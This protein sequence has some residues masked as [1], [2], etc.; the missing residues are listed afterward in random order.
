MGFVIDVFKVMLIDSTTNEVIATSVLQDA[1]IQRQLQS[2]E[3]RTG[4]GNALY[5]ELYYNPTVT[6]QLTHT[7]YEYKW[8]ARTLG[9][10][11]KTGAGTAWDFLSSY[12]VSGS[13]VV[14]PNA[15][16]A[17]SDVY[18]QNA[19][20]NNVTGF[21]LSGST[22]DFTA[23]TP[24]VAN[25]DVLSITYQYSS[26]PQTQTIDFDDSVFGKG[27]KIVLETVEM[28][29][30]GNPLY[31]IQYEYYNAVPDGQFTLN[32]QS[33]RQAVTQQMTFKV[34]SM[35]TDGSSK[36]GEVRR[37]PVS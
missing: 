12:T 5:G 23:A 24:A 25:S 9:E 26:D 21:T 15:P 11:I 2:Q 32:T 1:Q 7:F 17:V 8:L 36:V 14:L 3:I 30:G 20:G 10:T 37:I 34:V 29:G 27:C 4:V 22:L 33:Q 13:S 35:A 18:V 19:S 6:I 28:D 31:T 16:L